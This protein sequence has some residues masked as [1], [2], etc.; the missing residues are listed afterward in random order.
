VIVGRQ[1]HQHYGIVFTC[2]TC[3]AIHVELVPDLSADTFILALNNFT[4]GKGRVVRTIYSDNGTNFTGAARKLKQAF[5]RVLEDPKVGAEASVHGIDFQFNC[6]E[7]PHA[8]GIWEREVQSIKRVV[9]KLMKSRRLPVYTLKSFFKR[10]ENIVNS[11][12]LTYVPIDN[13]TAPALT[14]NMLLY[15]Y[16]ESGP[17]FD[18]SNDLKDEND[19]KLSRKHWKYVQ[20][21]ADHFWTRWVKK[22]LPELTRRSKWH[23][24]VEPLKVGDVVLIV[25]SRAKR[26]EFKRGRIVDAKETRSGQN[27]EFKVLCGETIYTRP[28]VKLAKLEFYQDPESRQQFCDKAPSFIT[29]GSVAKSHDKRARKRNQGRNDKRV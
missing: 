6:P 27:R 25:D 14:P 15:G 4:N 3:R 28:A 24:K 29:G 12:P 5:K 16:D 13:E 20:T 1:V 2:L 18:A 17:S 22:Y 8:G 11:Q 26:N 19:A 7:M 9:D 23:E 21:L 10:A